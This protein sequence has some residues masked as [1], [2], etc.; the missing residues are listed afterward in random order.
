MRPLNDLS[1]ALRILQLHGIANVAELA[2]LKDQEAMTASETREFGTR[3][4]RGVVV[5][6]VDQV[7]VRFEDDD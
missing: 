4:G 6:V 2:V 7:V 3:A 5:P 1:G